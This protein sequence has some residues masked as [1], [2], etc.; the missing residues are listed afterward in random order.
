[1]FSLHFNYVAC[2]DLKDLHWVFTHISLQLDVDIMMVLVQQ[3]NVDKKRLQN[4][5][6]SLHFLTH[7]YKPRLFSFLIY[8]KDADF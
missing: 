5:K 6:Q 7:G 2:P 8:N 1:M 4:L 3:T